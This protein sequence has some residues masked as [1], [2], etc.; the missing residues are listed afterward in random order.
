MLLDVPVGALRVLLLRSSLSEFLAGFIL[1]RIGASAS[2]NYRQA[3]LRV[4]SESDRGEDL[5]TYLKLR[6]RWF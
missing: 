2:R 5:P 4:G 1:S 6:R 3:R